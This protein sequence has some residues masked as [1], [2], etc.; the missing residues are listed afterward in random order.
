MGGPPGGGMGGPP[1]GAAGAQPI[2]KMP[3]INVWTILDKLL[4]GD[5][6]KK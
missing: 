2:F 4:S 3:E 6:K 5:E 1:G